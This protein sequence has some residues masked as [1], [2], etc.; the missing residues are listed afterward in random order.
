[1]VRYL[2]LLTSALLINM[3]SVQAQ[4]KKDAEIKSKLIAGPMLSYI[5][6]YHAQMWLLVD[7]S[8]KKVSI[9]LENFDE[10]RTLNM[11]FDLGDPE[12]FDNSRWYHQISNYN[13]GDDI[14]LI[15]NLEELLPDAEY[16]VEVYLDSVLVEEE[17]D[18]YT[19]RNYLAD[20]YFLFGHSLNLNS[21]RDKGD[22]IL[23]KMSEIE[24]DFMVWGGNNVYF[25]DNEV[26]AFKRMLNKYKYVRKREKVDQFMKQ[27]PHIATWNNMDFGLNTSDTRFALKDSS[28]MAFNMF[29]PNASKKVYNYSFRD[30]GVYK[31]YD[32]EDIEIFMLDNRMFK[33][34]TG[35]DDP[36]FFGA[37]QMNR[38]INEIMGSDASFKFIVSANSILSNGMDSEPLADYTEEYKELMNRLHLSRIDGVVFLTGD[39]KNVDLLKE[40]RDHAY[41]LY[42][43]QC[44][45]LSLTGANDGHFAR[46]KVEGDYNKRVCSL[47]VF[48][49][50]GKQ[51][52]K[53][54][55]HQSELSY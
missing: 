27:M 51:V 31:R 52:F 32:Y 12:T 24:S 13:L 22:A 17:M 16:H 6:D 20:I 3:G 40:E 55:L 44:P 5:D 36:Q 21:D 47:Q 2:L 14:P 18:I 1:M 53:K 33:T 41:P 11:H 46:V 4:K 34:T 10:D 8:T 9:R 15:L 43:L 19:P 26:D 50:S 48:D 49:A 54:K 45:G 28:L 37:N 23:D 42:E 29:W 39:T 7:K 30:Y 38:F 25:N 35:V